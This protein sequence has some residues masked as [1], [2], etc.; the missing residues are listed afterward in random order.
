MNIQHR[1][2]L[3]KHTPEPHFG[4]E[5]FIN[6]DQ[7]DPYEG[8]LDEESRRVFDDNEGQRWK[9]ITYTKEHD[10]LW[11]VRWTI[12]AIFATLGTLFIGVCVSSAIKNLWRKA[13]WG[14][15]TLYIVHRKDMEAVPKVDKIANEHLQANQQE[16]EMQ[17]PELKPEVKQEPVIQKEKKPELKQEPQIHEKEN[18][19][20]IEI[21]QNLFKYKMNADHS[22]SQ[23][24]F[25]IFGEERL[26]QEKG[27]PE[28]EYLPY[29]L[30]KANFDACIE[31]FLRCACDYW[32]HKKEKLN[33]KDFNVNQ[34]EFD[35]VKISVTDRLNRLQVVQITDRFEILRNSH[36]EMINFIQMQDLEAPWNESGLRIGLLTDEEFESLTMEQINALNPRQ[37]E[38]LGKRL[39]L[40]DFVPIKFA[41]GLVEAK[42]FKSVTLAQFRCLSGNKIESL[43]DLFSAGIMDLISE[44]QIKELKLTKISQ[45][46]FEV[47][48]PIGALNDLTESRIQSLELNQIQDL[49]DFDRQAPDGTRRF[50]ER[51]AMISKAQLQQ[52]DFT[53]YPIN[54][55][56]FDALFPERQPK[57]SSIQELSQDQLYDCLHLFDS[58]RIVLLYKDQIQKFDFKHPKFTALSEEKQKELLSYLFP[59]RDEKKIP[60]YFGID[61]RMDSINRIKLLEIDQI[62]NIWNFLSGDQ[63]CFMSVK[64]LEKL[65]FVKTFQNDPLKQVKFDE[66]FP[67]V[68]PNYYNNHP[69]RHLEPKQIY[70]GLKLKLFDADRIDI[71]TPYQ[72]RDIDFSQMSID[73]CKFMVDALFAWHGKANWQLMCER[74]QSVK[75]EQIEYLIP[76]LSNEFFSEMSLAQFRELDFKSLKKAQF[77]FI[78]YKVNPVH[79]IIKERIK[80]LSPEQIKAHPEFFD[81]WI[82]DLMEPEKRKLVKN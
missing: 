27:F 54:Q 32:M 58:K 11:Q 75:K 19:K 41:D 71:M 29:N 45:P 43:F 59:G 70:D 62:H 20:P 5:I 40:L 44:N 2:I 72:V 68:E 76:Y 65:D 61:E 67:R 14:K 49:L 3:I 1:P 42:N 63:L 36:P 79:E 56:K 73:D 80:N 4:Y 18:L 53:K 34:S 35:K 24:Q 8:K 6:P 31:N 66:L 82:I 21:H 12:A 52:I 38:L 60:D 64:Q 25:L 10:C 78:F 13:I 30:G 17:K 39:A 46:Q 77:D 33:G 48:L 69:F 23:K 22:L 28:Q 16:P 55:A 7:P 9:V 37:K 51:I 74:I 81:Q 57:N 15:K 50:D 26:K 47:F